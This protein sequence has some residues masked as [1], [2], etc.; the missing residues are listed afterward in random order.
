MPRVPTAPASSRVTPSMRLALCFVAIVC[1]LGI[2]IAW[3]G[4]AT[5][6]PTSP[7]VGVELP[8]DPP[9]QLAAT[10]GSA[11]AE[12]LTGSEVEPGPAREVAPVPA[13]PAEPSAQA[14]PRATIRGR[15]LDEDRVPAAGVRI[16]LHSDE[17]W[18]PGQD[19]PLVEFRTWKIEEF[20]MISRADGTFEVDVPVPVSPR[21]RLIVR[22]PPYLGI[23]GL[24]FSEGGGE[25]R[26]RISA[27]VND[28]GDVI[29]G[30][31]GAASGEVLTKDSSPIAGAEVSLWNHF[32]AGYVAR[33]TTDAAG[34]FELGNLPPGSWTIGVKAQGFLS[35]SMPGITVRKRATT[36]GLL[37]RLSTAPTI[38]GRVVDEEGRPLEKMWIWGWP[39]GSGQGAGDWSDADGAFVIHLPQAEPYRLELEERSNKGRFEPW[40]GKPGDK[41]FE[42]GTT[43]VLVELKRAVRTTFAVVDARTGAPVE[44]YGL[45]VLRKQN[46][47]QQSG[48]QHLRVEPHPGGECQLAAD[49]KLHAIQIVAPGYEDLETDVVHDESGDGRQTL[50]LEPGATLT[51]RVLVAGEPVAGAS[52]SIGRAYMKID[53][54]LPDEGDPIFGDPI[55]DDNY[56]TDL[57]PFLGRERSLESSAD[58]SFRVG[59]LAQGT[60]RLTVVGGSGAPKVLSSV[61]VERG[62]MRDLGEIVLDSAGSLH[63]RIVVGPG[64]EQVKLRLRVDDAWDGGVVPTGSEREF[65]IGN[66]TPGEHTLFVALDSAGVRDQHVVPFTIAAGITTELVVDVAAKSPAH[67]RIRVASRG[68]PRPGVQV[69]WQ[70]AADGKVTGWARLAD[71]DDE[72]VAE[73]KL[74]GGKDVEFVAVAAS[75]F[76]IGR[77]PAPVHLAGGSRHETDLEVR[78]GELVIELPGGLEIP[79]Q[80]LLGVV[81][82]GSPTPQVVHWSTPR[83]RFHMS[84]HRWT[85]LRCVVGAV[86]PGE[87]EIS[88]TVQ[89]MDEPGRFETAIEPF[90][91]RITI[92]EGESLTVAIDR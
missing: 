71:T 8:A 60:Y 7:A 10:P 22:P 32:P 51:G 70:G 31:T 79:E 66:L 83:S 5:L 21:V 20:S 77:S 24:S 80:G 43:D 69:R 72:G 29:L 86:A 90:T 35:S 39:V 49:P 3:L 63:G 82:H 56:T 17:P 88:V 89:R 64:Q 65:S 62:A 11:A 16:L 4:D 14:W 41:V 76:E 44:R 1:V 78:S 19:V 73:G 52:I 92:V 18:A 57:S 13:Q 81:L 40:G 74:P 23:A 33:T 46:G 48:H 54:S 12:I 84:E 75:G 87:Y 27:G 55:F 68:K 45:Y 25:S 47:V 34:R 53:P 28:V 6:E 61:R 58:G 50:E 85:D 30:V 42:P 36:P 9:A 26:P 15:L 91:S 67:V 37:F 38:S 2:G 59:D